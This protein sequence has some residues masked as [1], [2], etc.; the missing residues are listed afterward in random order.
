VKLELVPVVELVATLPDGAVLLDFG[1]NRA[2]WVQLSLRNCSAGTVVTLRHAEVLTGDRTALYVDNLRGA[3]ATDVYTCRGGAVV[4]EPRF[5]YHG[6]RFVEMSVNGTATWS[7]KDQSVRI[8]HSAVHPRGQISME[9]PVL[10]RIQDAILLTQSD[11][12]HSVPTDCPQRDERQGWMADAAVSAEQAMHNFDMY[13]FYGNWLQVVVDAQETNNEFG[14][15]HMPKG[16]N[17]TRM[18]TGAVADTSP[19]LP[20]TYGQ[21]PADPSWGIALPL[22]AD[23][24]GKHYGSAVAEKFASPVHAWADFLL[25]VREESGIVKYHYYGDWLQP[26]KVPSD[27]LISYMAAGFSATLALE[28][29]S[30]I[31]PAPDRARFAQEFTTMRSKY[32]GVYWNGTLK[33]FGDGTQAAQVFALKLGGLSAAQD[34]AAWSRLLE[35][36]GSQGINTGIIATKWLFPLLSERGRTDLGL[37]LA[38]SSAYPSWGYMLAKDATT[39]WEHWDA[40]GHGQS[41]HMSSH[42]HP[43]FTSVGAWFYTDLV[44]IR[45]DPYSLELGPT[46]DMHNDLLPSASGTLAVDDGVAKV[47]WSTR[48]IV[49]IQGECPRTKGCTVR[50]PLDGMKFQEAAAILGPQAGDHGVSPCGRSACVQVLRGAFAL[51]LRASSL[52]V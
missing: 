24:L 51:M 47:S 44:G 49:Q 36:L 43:A 40:F 7:W 2:G 25:S 22:I 28:F 13:T 26:G 30:K 42:N 1:K 45:V 34:K 37:Q 11:N 39:I 41:P 17:S 15:C 32:L 27:P 48:P 12:L 10:T 52:I 20:G 29:A 19:H 33:S 50:V 14:D 35:L 31:G 9:N 4:H 16:I 6:F 23:L 21:R 3:K 18:C 38:S 5:T 46:L 8:V